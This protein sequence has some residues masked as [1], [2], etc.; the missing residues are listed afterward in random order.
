MQIDNL[1]FK[2]YL[3]NISF[4]AFFSLLNCIHFLDLMVT[5]QYKKNCEILGIAVFHAIYFVFSVFCFK[6]YDLTHGEER[7]YVQ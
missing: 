5:C 2:S 7:L 3:K 6:V 1:D 4:V